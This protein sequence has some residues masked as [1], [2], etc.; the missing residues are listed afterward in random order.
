MQARRLI[1]GARRRVGDEDATVFAI[2]CSDA[3]PPTP[4]NLRALGRD[5]S[6]SR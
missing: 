4:D 2:D 5:V 6:I 1:V 3:L